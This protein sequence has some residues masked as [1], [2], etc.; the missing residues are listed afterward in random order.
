MSAEPREIQLRAAGARLRALEWPGSA[1]PVVLSHATSF[2]ADT[3]IPAW[4]AA[5]AAGVA[6]RA[7]ALDQRGH[8]GSFA[9]RRAEDY[10]W[11][12]LAED[13]AGVLDA[14]EEPALLVGHS[15]G[16][17]ASLAA[18]GLRPD[19]VAGVALVEPVLFD[20]PARAGLDSFAGSQA[21]V[22]RARKRRPAFA[23]RAAARDALRER[24][25]YAGFA[26]DALEAYLDGGFEPVGGGGLAL[27]CAPEVEAWAYQGAAALD[28]WPLVARVRA[29]VRL[30]LA[31]HSAVPPELRQRL[32][33]GVGAVRV[34][35]IEGATHF[36]ALERPDA[37][38][39]RL[40]E[41]AAE[42][43]R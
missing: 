34:T 35:R 10:G 41:F 24:F 21:L 9:P 17:T 4:R 43:S 19:R 28:V 20:P 29:P 37:V 8:G 2:C 16:A 30:L 22:E 27:R 33:E 23:G 5:R 25:P 7:L 26:A 3:W 42:V 6:S 15:S 18:A 12:R 1:P 36:A 13:L 31:E 14:L 38:G 39:E 40:A 11:D 32:I